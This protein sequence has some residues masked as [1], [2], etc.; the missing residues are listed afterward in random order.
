M[1]FYFSGTG[2]S[3]YIA[4]KTADLLGERLVSIAAEMNSSK[5]EYTYKLSDDEAIGFVFPVYAWA[6]PRIAVEFIERL[7]LTDNHSRYV[8]A[9]AVCGDEAG[10]AVKQLERSLCRAGFKLDSAFSV[11]MPNNY[12]ILFDV[13]SKELE[14]RKLAGAEKVIEKIAKTVSDQ[15]SGVFDVFKGSLAGLKTTLIGSLF[16]RFA[17]GTR[18]FYADDK[19]TGCGI[20]EKICSLGNITVKGRPKWGSNCTQCLACLHYCHEKA[21]QYGK[22]TR[23]KGRY[24]NPNVEIKEMLKR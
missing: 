9:V 22:G 8:Y 16:N 15:K 23:N 11:T 2:N 5:Q 17:T 1:I 14:R 20:C 10:N 6:P 21:I 19:C 13:D 12:V 3:Y 24:V 7:R 18:A 4:R